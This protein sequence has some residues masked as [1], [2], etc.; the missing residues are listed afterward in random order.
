MVVPL[1]AFLSDEVAFVIQV[2][3]W[4]GPAWK[5][6]AVRV[7]Q[8]LRAAG[9]TEA[10]VKEAVAFARARMDLIR[11][12]APYEDLEKAQAKVKDKAWFKSVDWC[13]RTLFH[14]ARRNV[15]FDTGPVWEKV[16]CPVLAIYGDKDTSSGPHKELEAIIRRGM[17]KGGNEGLLV[18]LFA[19]A[20]HSL[21][22]TGKGAG[23]AKAGE[24]PDF[25]PGY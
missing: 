19:D 11:G 23:V 21:C 15:N 8:E 24:G 22:R 9:S 17:Q 16:R 5:Q 14:W 13:E 10:D 4:Q 7:Q 6:D 18:W 20:D 3:G 1:A 25:I 2:S 12:T